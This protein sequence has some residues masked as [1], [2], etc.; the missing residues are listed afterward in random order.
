MVTFLLL[1]AAIFAAKASGE[2]SPSLFAPTPVEI[3]SE[4][5]SSV[6]VRSADILYDLGCGDGRVPIITNM[7]YS[8]ECIGI[9]LDETVASDAVEN[10]RLNNL[11]GKIHIY[12]GDITTSDFSRATLV[13]LYLQ[14]ELSEKIRARLLTLAP[15]SRIIAYDKRLPKWQ[16]TRIKKLSNGKS[17]YIY[18]IPEKYEKW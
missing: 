8:I 14:P 18:V 15:G 5:L 10:V 4:I 9:E 11:E 2:V 16:P 6:K 1:G 17:L 3:I 12:Q 7:L 13:Y